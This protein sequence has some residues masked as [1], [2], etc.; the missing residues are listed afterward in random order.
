[1]NRKCRTHGPVSTR[2]EHALLCLRQEILDGRVAPGEKLAEFMV[3]KRLG[4][5]RV[6][7]REA[8]AALER[9]GLVE[10]SATGRAYVKELSVTDFEELFTLRLALEPLAARLAA[11]VIQR[12]AFALEENIRAT[13]GAKT[14]SEVTRLDMDF[15]QV[16]IEASGNSRLV[17]LWISLRSELELWLG[18]LHRSKEFISR[19]TREETVKSHLEI[20]ECFKT[21]TTVECER[22][23]RA[24]IQGW[25]E[26]LPVSSTAHA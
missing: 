12:D 26:W 13:R 9:E 16:I 23:C 18:R 11:P 22:L 24:H 6:P 1:M 5:S 14:L 19:G 4:V 17:K 21:G 8:L 3:G 10:F 25:R 20:L 7:V 15:H 2:T